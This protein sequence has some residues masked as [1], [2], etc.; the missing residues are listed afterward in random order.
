MNI[1]LTNEQLTN[2]NTDVTIEFLT[3][4]ELESNKLAL[5]LK[6]AGFKAEQDS[7]LFLHESNILVCGIDEHDNDSIRSASSSAVKLLRASNNTNAKI[8]ILS[9]ETIKGFVILLTLLRKN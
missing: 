1:K 7:T 5:I 3:K 2:L 9:I 6:K 8:E 4:D